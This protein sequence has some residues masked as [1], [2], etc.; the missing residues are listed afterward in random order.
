[1]TSNRRAKSGRFLL[2]RGF[3]ADGTPLGPE[4]VVNTGTLG[5]QRH[6]QAAGDAQGGFVV[7]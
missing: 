7:T 4:T 2:A 1:M 5:A 6:P 3:G